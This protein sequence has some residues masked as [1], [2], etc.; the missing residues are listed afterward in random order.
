M[1]PIDRSKHNAEGGPNPLEKKVKGTAVS[2]GK[3]AGPVVCLFGEHR[4]FFRREVERSQISAE[5]S[6]LDSAVETARRQLTAIQKRESVKR[7]ASGKDILNTHLQILEDSSLIARINDAIGSQAVNAEWA[8]KTVCDAFVA[9]YQAIDDDHLRE[10]YID[11]ED[12]AERIL[13]ALG[14]SSGP[15]FNLPPDAVIAAREIRPSTIIELFDGSTHGII[16]ENGGWTSHTFILARELG[17]P[18]VTGVKNIYR[19]LSSGR[20]ALVDGFSGRVTLDPSKSTLEKGTVSRFE[21][22]RPAINASLSEGTVKTLDGLGISIYA[23]SESASAYH[24]AVRAGARGVG[25]YRSEYLF[26]RHRGFP[27]EA[28]QY[29]AYCEIG[30]A[31]GDGGVKIR[32]FDVG[33]DRMLD[34][35]GSREKNPALGLKG[36]RFG[37][38]DRKH[39][40]EQLRAII[41]A[42]AGRRVDIVIPMVSGLDELRQARKI[43]EAEHSALVARGKNA[44]RPGLGVMIEIPSAALLIEKVVREADFVCVG[45]NDLIQY[46]LA[47]DRDD[48]DVSE[49]YR[50][51]HPAVL[52]VI[53]NIVRA[54]AAVNK[55]AIICGEMAGSPFYVPL[56][57]GLGA[58]EL[59][60]NVNSISRVIRVAQGIAADEARKLFRD[61]VELETVE[62]VESKVKDS[63][64][65]NWVHLFPAKF[66]FR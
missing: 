54:A 39:L 4:Q 34:Q 1:S 52:K 51:L 53:H 42:S 9:K 49:W 43:V 48:E 3:I 5:I 8:V 14:G 25:L 61:V 66:S 55:K 37:L 64:R 65:K 58:T 29:R 56:L 13:S 41:R 10:R 38:R 35:G 7:A 62:E 30:D 19:Q 50:T 40:R 24:E 15:E 60:M 23:N 46:L 32:T 36:I 47:A 27:S 31:S 44:G 33:R 45:T 57:I 28:V 6:R 26:D 21:S 2:R 18:A 11:I 16:T 63:I 12:V 22:M 17:W 20:I 59:S